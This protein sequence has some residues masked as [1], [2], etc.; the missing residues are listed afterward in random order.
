MNPL[1]L[2]FLPLS[3]LPFLIHFLN[4]RRS[5]TVLFSSLVFLKGLEKTRLRKIQLKQWLLLLLRTLVVGF[6]ILA[7][8]RPS[9]HPGGPAAGGRTSAVLVFD[10]GFQSSQLT[11]DGIVWE[12]YRAAGEEALAL[13]K[14]GDEVSVSFVSEPKAEIVLSHDLAAEG[15]KLLKKEA[16]ATGVSAFPALLQAGQLLSGSHNPNREIYFFS[17]GRLTPSPTAAHPPA[18]PVRSRLF[19]LKPDL[20]DNDNRTLVSLRFADPVLAAGLPVRVE[21]EVFN[22]R[23]APASGVSVSLYLDGKKV[24]QQS[25]DLGPEETRKILLEGAVFASGWHSGYLELPDDDLLADN[26]SYFSFYLRP[27]L[28]LLLASDAPGYWN[29]AELVL[30]AGQKTGLWFEIQRARLSEFSR[31]DWS[32][33]DAAFVALPEKFDYGWW[34]RILRF[35]GEGGGVLLAPERDLK[36]YP[37]A[38][39]EQLAGLKL[40]GPVASGGGEFFSFR[41]E[42]A[43]PI[44]SFLTPGKNAPAVK[45][46][47]YHKNR[48]GRESFTAARFAQGGAALVEKKTEKGRLLFS[49]ASLERTNT[50]LYFHAFAVPFFFRTAQYLASF[51]AQ[52]ND[53]KTGE[54]VFFSPPEFPKKFPLKLSGP[55]GS[56]DRAV[57]S[58]KREGFLD[59]GVLTQPGIYRLYADT[60]LVGMAAVNVDTKSSSLS[61]ISAAQLEKALPGLGVSEIRLGEEIEP[62]VRQSRSGRELWKLL[63]F[64]V[65]GLLGLEMAIVRWGEKPAPAIPA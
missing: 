12:R 31:L 55:D 28:R 15:E 38:V 41:P 4:R 23:K 44:F 17:G 46:F 42:A 3:S 34:E 20:E 16:V 22:Q 37:A 61:P 58:G 51:T 6:S 30:A 57:L 33:V 39:F 59:L 2:F 19:W 25:V 63:A 36:N 52:E 47:S 27:K 9:W 24:G 29:A 49:A 14:N 7:F 26:R 5:Q 64:T 48:P 35:A 32:A 40:E 65:L 60:F 45:F 10:D 8:A 11:K 1:F 54:R 56:A 62:V 13:L 21:G 50:D 18:T 43:H 53:F